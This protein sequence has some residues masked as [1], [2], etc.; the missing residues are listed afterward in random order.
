MRG[1]IMQ[2]ILKIGAIKVISERTLIFCD[3][4]MVFFRHFEH[5]DLLVGGKVGLLDVDFVNEDVRR[6][7]E[8]ARRLL[9]LSPNNGGYRNYVGNMICWNRETVEAM[10][11]R[12][13]TSTGM[14][15]QVALARTLRF[16]EYMIYGIFVRE[17]SGY[18][19]TDHAPS[20]VPLV[21]GAWGGALAT[22]SAIDAFFGDFDPRT[23]A[24]MVHSKDGI[25]LGRYRPHLE[26]CWNE[27][28]LC[29]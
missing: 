27:G 29:R 2:Q 18:S 25:D 1:W 8:T 26:R 17:V 13:E 24:V 20:A 4:D 7:T 16:S 6:W 21:K 23:V 5:D 19:A 11:Q 3:S 12:I 14:N 22:D 28:R 10:Q 9:G 15:W